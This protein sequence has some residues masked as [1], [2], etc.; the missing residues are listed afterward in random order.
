MIEYEQWLAKL[1][2]VILSVGLPMKILKE[3]LTK[4]SGNTI[5]MKEILQ[6]LY[7]RISKSLFS[8]CD[9]VSTLSPF[10]TMYVNP[11]YQVYLIQ[12]LTISFKNDSHSGISHNSDTC[13]SSSSY[14]ELSSWV[15]KKF[16]FAGLVGMLFWQS[17][18]K[19]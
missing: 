8:C 13:L 19:S 10:C 12:N 15:D 9:K 3:L 16:S 2:A 4:P 6:L 18:K 14:N 1:A 5:L 11:N 17:M 7:L